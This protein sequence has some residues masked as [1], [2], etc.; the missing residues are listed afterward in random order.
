[1]SM[2]ESL[3]PIDYEEFLSQNAEVINQDPLKHL[4]LFPVDDVLVKTIPRKIRTIDHIRPNE[5][6]SVN[7]EMFD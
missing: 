4:L 2:T 1:M 3:E 5:N 6:M 7:I